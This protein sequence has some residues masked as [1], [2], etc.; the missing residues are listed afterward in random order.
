MGLVAVGAFLFISWYHSAALDRA[1]MR[2]RRARRA[3]LLMAPMNPLN[4]MAAMRFWSRPPG[5]R[6]SARLLSNL[7]EQIGPYTLS[8]R[9]VRA[10]DGERDLFMPF[11]GGNTPL[12]NV[13]VVFQVVSARPK[14][15]RRCELDI[16]SI[17]A[18]DDTGQR[19]RAIRRL[20]SPTT[21]AHGW[22]DAILLQAPAPSARTLTSVEG[23]LRVTAASGQILRRPF[24]LTNVPLPRGQRLYGRVAPRI[25]PEKHARRLP[26]GL[27][28]LTGAKAE[29][30]L[31][32]STPAPIPA[33][34][35]P[36]TLVLAPETPARLRVPTPA[37]ATALTLNARQGPYGSIPL[38]VAQNRPGD[39]GMTPWQGDVW[40][41]EPFAIV[42][43]PEGAGRARQVVAMR[44][45]RTMESI[46]QTLTAP[47]I[48]P[49]QSGHPGG[50]ISSSV[51]VGEERF[52][53]GTLNVRLWQ[54]VGSGWSNPQEITVPLQTDGTF[55]L[56]NVEPGEYRM[57]RPKESL[58]PL[59]F[60]A[61]PTAPVEVYIKARFGAT[62]GAWH[63]ER[64]EHLRV[65]P[66]QRT[67]VPPL[68][69][70]PDS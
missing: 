17:Q 69:W 2:A 38:Q 30:V 65:Y 60:P 1:Q 35:P 18:Q 61:E 70:R 40:D 39:G 43:A 32:A 6:L 22:Y 7:A 5:I 33:S 59:Q 11:I 24:R 8:I 16:S 51:R 54:R 36:Q 21:F 67:E 68:W 49:A 13:Q 47:P 15:E 31:R 66:G 57:E 28:V 4:P 50:A 19:L 10:Q 9:Q 53:A 52:G 26:P 44:L 48:F 42:L 20:L 64:V 63:G 29:A 34:L 58:K 46:Y 25:L 27:V 3:E 14:A 45:S 55:V 23:T 12:G 62:G 56:P 41:D 37:D